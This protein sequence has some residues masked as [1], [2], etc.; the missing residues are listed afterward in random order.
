MG[1]WNVYR[2]VPF[3]QQCLKI[4]LYFGSNLKTIEFCF[5]YSLAHPSK[6]I[7][8]IPWDF[9]EFLPGMLNLKPDSFFSFL[10]RIC[11]GCWRNSHQPMFDSKYDDSVTQIPSDRWLTFIYWQFMF[12]KKDKRLAVKW[13]ILLYPCLEIEWL[14]FTW[15]RVVPSAD[16]T[17]A[18]RYQIQL[19]M[20]IKAISSKHHW[21]KAKYN[22]N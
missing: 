14:V 1:L 16:Q 11:G 4:C 19:S 15:T 13:D 9:S 5:I 12:G 20:S 10:L 18:P 17:P 21:F 22:E 8:K 3:K 6:I 7:W 2:W